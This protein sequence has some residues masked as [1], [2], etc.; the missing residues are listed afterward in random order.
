MKT[1]DVAGR[2]EM[3]K[4]NVWREERKRMSYFERIFGFDWRFV[5]RNDIYSYLENDTET[6]HDCRVGD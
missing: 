4:R 2:I 5:R 6:R 1:V 3:S